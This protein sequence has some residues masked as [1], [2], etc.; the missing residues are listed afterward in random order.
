MQNEKPTADDQVTQKAF[1]QWSIGMYSGNSP[2]E[3]QAMP[4]VNNPIITH[5]DVTDVRAD[6]VADPFMIKVKDLWYLFFELLDADKELGAIGVSTSTDALTWDY[7][8]LVLETGHH[9]SYPHI[10]EWDDCFYMIPESYSAEGIILYKAANFPFD[11]QP[12]TTLVQGSFADA[13]VFRHDHTWWMFASPDP[14]GFQTL[15]LY[16]A[17]ELAG[18]WLEHPKNPVVENDVHRARPAGKVIEW[19]GQL[20][21]FAQDCK[22]RYGSQVRVLSITTLNKQDYQESEHAESPILSGSGSSWN[23]QRMHHI[24]L[25]LMP[26][27]AWMACVD[28]YSES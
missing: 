19:E 1:R 24:D 15:N 23:S 8:G 27:G 4:G 11:W 18:P 13:T 2:F 16:Y 20:L 3:L 25:H 5:V 10:M 22:P 21:R 17:D 26:N 7:K 14:F 12:V 9:L 28:G 6:F